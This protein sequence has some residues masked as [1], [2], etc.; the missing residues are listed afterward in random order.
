[1]MTRLSSLKRGSRAGDTVIYAGVQA[2][3]V[4]LARDGNRGDIALCRDM[5]LVEFAL[6]RW[7]AQVEVDEGKRDGPTSAERDEVV[8]LRKRV[9]VLEEELNEHGGCIDLSA[10]ARGP[11]VH[12]GH[13]IAS[14]RS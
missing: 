13:R 14:P 5:D 6:S 11:L 3:G 7:I 12:C 9:H 8:A 1:M 10:C 2:R 4:A